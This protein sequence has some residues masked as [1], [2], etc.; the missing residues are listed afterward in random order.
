MKRIT[1]LS[2]LLL[3]TFIFPKVYSQ[4]TTGELAG[5]VNPLTSAVP[6]LLIAP[7]ARAGAM[8]DVGAATTPDVYSSHWNPAKYAFIE[9][10]M[11]FSVAYSPWLRELVDDINLSYLTGYKRID[12]RQTVAFSFLYFSLGNIMFT[13]IVGNTVRNYNPNEFAIDASYS[14]LLSKNLSGGVS[15][16][17]IYSNLTGGTYIDGAESHAG[18]SVAADISVYYRKD[19]KLG[20]KEGEMA[21]G[22]SISNIGNK[23]SYTDDSRKDFIPTNLRMGGSLSV[24]FDDYNKFSIAADINKL[25]I[26]TPPVYDPQKPGENVILYGMD[27]NVSVA[28]GLFQSFYDAPGGFEE[29]LNEIA[30]SLGAEYWYANQFAV[31]TGYFHESNTKGNRKFFTFG[32]GLRLNVFGLDIAYLRPTTRHHPLENTIRLSLTFNFEGLKKEA[33]ATN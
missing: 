1:L 25:L 22:G 9:K 7:D 5:Q 12:K 31:R 29:E 21:F 14:L 16:R 2:F 28:S 24:Q 15:L 23:I 8:G 13:D 33:A 27:N 6:F 18:T 26:P 17:Y 32:L 4:I 11:G 19:V 10:D 3:C 20:E 30:F